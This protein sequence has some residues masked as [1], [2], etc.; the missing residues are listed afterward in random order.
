MSMGELEKLI[1]V[2][3]DIL[4]KD[5]QRFR[6][7]QEAMNRRIDEHSREED[8][9]QQQILTTQKWHTAIGTALI[10]VFAGHVMKSGF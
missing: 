3:M 8:K 5:F 10:A 2:K 1:E 9:V 4:I 7:M 6:D